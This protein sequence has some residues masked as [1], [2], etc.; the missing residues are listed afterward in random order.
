MQV[1]ST[2]LR[3]MCGL[4]CRV[5]RRHV[6]PITNTYLSAVHAHRPDQLPAVL[7]LRI[8]LIRICPGHHNFTA[9]IRMH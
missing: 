1:V 9:S 2:V 5:S 3:A 7:P 8:E 4:Q 6:R